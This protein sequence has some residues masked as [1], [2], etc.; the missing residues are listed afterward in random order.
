MGTLYDR[1]ISSSYTE[2]LKTTSTGGVT[3]T[4]AHS[5]V[6]ASEDEAGSEETLAREEPD[7]D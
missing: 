5:A 6:E 4:L 7:E 3:A 1:T 2:L